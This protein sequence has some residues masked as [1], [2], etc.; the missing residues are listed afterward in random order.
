MRGQE[1]IRIASH[2]NTSSVSD[3]AGLR[4]QNLSSWSLKSL[5]NLEKTQNKPVSTLMKE[6]TSES[7]LHTCFTYKA[8][9][10]RRHN[11]FWSSSILTSYVAKINM[12]KLFSYSL[13]LIIYYVIFLLSVSYSTHFLQDPGLKQLWKMAEFSFLHLLNID[14]WTTWFGKFSG[15]WLW[16]NFHGDFQDGVYSQGKHWKQFSVSFLVNGFTPHD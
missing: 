7:T 13:I 3:A 14:I 15:H 6:M 16:F 10:N 5:R 8:D 1:W 4:L 2:P 11:T 12:K 9:K